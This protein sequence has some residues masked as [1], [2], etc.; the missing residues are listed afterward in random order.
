MATLN[1]SASLVGYNDDLPN[2]PNHHRI[3]LRSTASHITAIGHNKE[4]EMLTI[5]EIPQQKTGNRLLWKMPDM[6]SGKYKFLLPAGTTA[7]DISIQT[8]KY[9]QPC[10]ASLAL[11]KDP[12]LFPA[13]EITDTRKTLS[14][15]LKGQVLSAFSPEN[16]GTLMISNTERPS[17]VKLDQ[18]R[19]LY[20]NFNFPAGKALN[21]QSIIEIDPSVVQEPKPVSKDEKIIALMQEAGLVAG[22]LELAGFSEAQLVERAISSG[23]W[24]ALHKFY[25]LAKEA[26]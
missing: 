20:I 8:Y 16:S 18:D 15:L 22:L 9:D 21:V 2:L 26:K 12:A 25:D 19:W 1:T 6:G 11:D 13:V 23:T 3:S 10:V 5:Q 17:K 14:E 4:I 24:V 7:W